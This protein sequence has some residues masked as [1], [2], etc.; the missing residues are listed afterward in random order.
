MA[1]LNASGAQPCAFINARLV[2]PESGYDGVG[3]LV[4]SKGVIA[5]VIHRPSFDTLSDDL[6]VIDCNGAM[7]APGLID[8][9]VKTGEPGAE[10]KETLKLSLIHI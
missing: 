10:T 7:L 9:R 3:A 2:D 5:D 6:R 4:V 1:A 8:L